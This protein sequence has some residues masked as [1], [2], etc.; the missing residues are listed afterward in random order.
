MY[1]FETVVA[2]GREAEE[3]T[4]AYY[5]FLR[6][7]RAPS[8]AAAGVRTEILGTERRCTVTLWSEEAHHEFRGYLNRFK[9]PTPL[10]LT[11]RYGP[12]I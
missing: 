3:V 4:S 11:P 2:T 8:E 12:Q 9:L 7:R 6:A 10:P 1:A 5:A